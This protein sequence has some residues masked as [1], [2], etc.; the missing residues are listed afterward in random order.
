MI[1][2]ATD[3]NFHGDVLRGLL[4]RFPALDVLR[5]Q[6]T[7]IFGMDD[8]A[9]LEWC[10]RENRVLFTHDIRTIPGFVNARLKRSEPVSGVVAAPTSMSV[11]A[12]VEDLVFIV[13]CTDAAEW[14]NRIEYLPL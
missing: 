10:A 4:R 14:Q 6:D 9:L 13:E 2:V 5:V 1:R 12:M 3:E 11:G 8:P 7:E